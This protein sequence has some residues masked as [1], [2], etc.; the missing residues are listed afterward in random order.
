MKTLY[1]TIKE[2]GGKISSHYSDLYVE[3]SNSVSDAITRYEKE[4]GVKVWKQCFID[5]TT[6]KL[7]Y[8]IPFAF[9]P[10]WKDKL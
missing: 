2:A 5:Q 3:V 6:N 10:Y 9:D 7:S 4:N 1:Q 8:D